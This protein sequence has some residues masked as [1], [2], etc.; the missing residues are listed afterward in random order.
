MATDKREPLEN[1]PKNHAD[2]INW[3]TG[4][5]RVRNTKVSLPMSTSLLTIYYFFTT[6]HDNLIKTQTLGNWCSEYLQQDQ[7][8]L[9]PIPFL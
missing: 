5:S 1:W 9:F 4:S 3:Q 6:L 8:N 7:N 2:N